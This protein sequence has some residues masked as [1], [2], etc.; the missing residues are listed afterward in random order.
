M[1]KCRYLQYTLQLFCYNCNGFFNS[2][3]IYTCI[4]ATVFCNNSNRNIFAVSCVVLK[5]YYLSGL[6]LNLTTCTTDYVFKALLYFFLLF[7][8]VILRTHYFAGIG[9]GMVVVSTLVSIYYNMVIGWALY[10]LVA[11]FFELPN[12]DLPWTK[13]LKGDSG[14]CEYKYQLKTHV[15]GSSPK[16]NHQA[17]TTLKFS[18][19]CPALLSSFSDCFISK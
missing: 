17:F 9:W 15:A 2:F 10:Y 19:S 8:C 14:P 12:D 7:S 18:R 11:S 5:F 13:C 3:S 1:K 4:W 16:P 6:L